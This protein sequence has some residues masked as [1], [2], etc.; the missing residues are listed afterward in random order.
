MIL[1]REFK[2]DRLIECVPNFS[3][4]KNADVIKEIIK[5]IGA[6]KDV[7]VLDFSLDVDHNRAVVTFVGPP[8][9]VGEGAFNAIKRASELIDMRYHKGQHPRIGATDVVPFVPIRNVT[10]S[11]CVLIARGVAKKVGEELNIPVYLYN[12][13]A[14]KPER[15]EL[16]NIR[17]GEY[18]ALCLEM[19]SSADRTP[20]FG[21]DKMNPTAG[22]TVIGARAPLVA[23]NVYLTATDIKVARTIAKTIR[24]SS[25]GMPFVKAIGLFFPDRNQTQVSMN[26]TNYRGTPIRKVYDEIA[27][28]AKE[29]GADTVESEV[30]GLLP[31]DAIEGDLLAHGKFLT[32]KPEQIIENRI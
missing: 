13:A 7:K 32:F 23:Y 12:E 1:F 14:F 24:E 19:G 25:G 5:A 15:K 16:P 3:E 26:L 10:M 30:I 6:A 2:M 31:Q 27:R 9:T 28:L 29:H 22:A 21:P 4:G 8:E 11:D 17:K 20:D 18:E